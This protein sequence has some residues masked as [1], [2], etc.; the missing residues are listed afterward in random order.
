[1]QKMA[2]HMDFSVENAIF[3]PKFNKNEV[4]WL[5]TSYLLVNFATIWL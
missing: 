5:N 4:F 2:T 3:A 1:M